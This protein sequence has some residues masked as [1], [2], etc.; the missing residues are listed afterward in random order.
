MTFGKVPKLAFAKLTKLV[1][2]VE[3]PLGRETSEKIFDSL[4]AKGILNADGKILPAFDPKAP[5]FDLGLPPE[6]ADLR[7]NV[8]EVLQ[9]YQLERHIKK[10]EDGKRLVFKKG[11]ELDEGFKALW[12]R[13][14]PQTTY[15]V[16][17]QTDILV[18]NAVKAIK[19]MEKINP[20]RVHISEA[21]LDIVRAGIEA[22]VVRESTDAVIFRGAV[23]DVI[24]YARRAGS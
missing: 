23:P 10:D 8:I 21:Q 7:A 2:D 5:G 13:I 17:Y 6:H 22:D 18:T 16:E 3:K 9:S 11:I 14:S 4:I 19:A 20:V 1:E 24:A 12:E 15:S